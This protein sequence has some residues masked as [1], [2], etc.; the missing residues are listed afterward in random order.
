MKLI[1]LH[2][3]LFYFSVLAQNTALS[4]SGSYTLLNANLVDSFVIQ[5]S[6]TETTI[7]FVSTTTDGQLLQL[8]SGNVPF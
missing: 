6:Q 1:L 3:L 7:G 4:T 5:D 8:S 2:T